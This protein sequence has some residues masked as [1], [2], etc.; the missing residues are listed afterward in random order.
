[1]VHD[2][3]LEDDKFGRSECF[4]INCVLSGWAR[5]DMSDAELLEKGIECFEGL[6]KEVQ[7]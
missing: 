4:G 1:M 3:D 5:S 2:A 6:Y 7:K